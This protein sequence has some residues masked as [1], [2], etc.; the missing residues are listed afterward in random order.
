[1]SS[2]QVRGFYLFH[3]SIPDIYYFQDEDQD[4]GDGGKNF[5]KIVTQ[6]SGNRTCTDEK[7]QQQKTNV[8]MVKSAKQSPLCVP[9]PD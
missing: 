5:Y 7:H 9:E 1:M 4:E 8:K 6:N 3:F 2:A